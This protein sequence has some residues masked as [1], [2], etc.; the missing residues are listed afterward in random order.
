V[1][2]THEVF[3]LGEPS[4]TEDYMNQL[5]PRFVHETFVDIDDIHVRNAYIAMRP[6]VLFMRGG[7]AAA[8][9]RPLR[10]FMNDFGQAMREIAE[11]NADRW[12]RLDEEEMQ[13]I[14]PL[15][16]LPLPDGRPAQQA[17]QVFAGRG[18]RLPVMDDLPRIPRAAQ[19]Q[20]QRLAFRRCASPCSSRRWIE[21]CTTNTPAKRSSTTHN[22]A[23]SWREVPSR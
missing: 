11:A 17:F 10:R 2:A 13:V 18:H 21:S 3:D 15:R 9:A 14:A 12:A 5:P 22:S 20:A 23:A 19:E 4:F 16:N 8:L 1:P 7:A 6:F